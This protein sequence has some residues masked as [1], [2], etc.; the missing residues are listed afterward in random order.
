[1]VRACLCVPTIQELATN[2][3]IE[4]FFHGIFINRMCDDDAAQQQRQVSS[5]QHHWHTDEVGNWP[6]L[7]VVYM[8][9]NSLINSTAMSALEAGEAYSMSSSDDGRFHRASRSQPWSTTSYYPKTNSFYIFPGY[10]VSHTVYKLNSGTVRYFIVMFVCLRCK[11]CSET[12]DH[13]TNKQTQ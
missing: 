9:F 3:P 8:V 13:Y 11:F 10:F 6:I 1:M 2:L 7:T 12:V 4:R 5:M